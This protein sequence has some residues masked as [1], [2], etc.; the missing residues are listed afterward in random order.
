MFYNAIDS[1]LF[2]IGGKPRIKLPRIANRDKFP[3]IR[4]EHRDHLKVIS[5]KC[6]SFN[7]YSS[8]LIFFITIN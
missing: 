1:N 4:G 6:F 2:R 3:E 7:E 8:I 5:G